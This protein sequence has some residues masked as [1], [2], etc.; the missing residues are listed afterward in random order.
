MR[1]TLYA[2]PFDTMDGTRFLVNCAAHPPGQLV[3]LM[4]WAR[5][6]ASN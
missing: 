5:L 1:G 6:G 2:H 4:N 3:V